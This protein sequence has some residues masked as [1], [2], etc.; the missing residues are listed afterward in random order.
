MRGKKAKEL[1]REMELK[2]A[3]KR[4]PAG[5]LEDFRKLLYV[6]WKHLRLPDPTP[7]QYDIAHF[8]QHG[9]KRKGIQGFRGV[10]K[11]WVTSA[12]VCWLLLRNPQE[13]ILV[14]SASKQRSDDFSTFTLR[15]I[16]EIPYLNHLIPNP[17]QRESKIAFD[18]APSMAAHA[19][20][21]KAA[22]IFG[23]ITGSRATHIIADDVEVA[24]NALTEDMRE[25]LL[26]AVS[27]FEAILVPEGETSITFLGTPQTHESIYNKMRE[28][29]YEF[30]VWPARYPDAVFL[31]D[32]SQDV[33]NGGLAPK[34]R[35]R[36]EANPK[37]SGEPTDPQRFDAQ[38]LM[39]RE[40]SYG[41]SGFGLQFMLDTTMSDLNRYPLKL[42][43][44]V[45]MDL[46][47]ERAPTGIQYGSGAEQHLK[48]IKGI[49]LAGDR[50]FGPMWYDK[51]TWT[52][53]EGMVMAIDPS[54]RGKDE[55]AY[56]I[57]A[58]LHGKLFLLDAG[59]L[60]GGYSDPVLKTLAIKAKKYKVKRILIEDNFG[61]GMFEALLKPH[62]RK[63]YPCT[64][65]GVRHNTMKEARIIDTLEPVL[66]QHRLVV[67][68]SL[69]KKDVAQATGS[70]YKDGDY[71]DVDTTPDGANA[72]AYSLFYQ[73]TRLTRERGSLKHDDR[74]DCVSIAVAY[75]L[76]SM[77]KDEQ[78]S[79]KDHHDNMLQKELDK[80]MDGVFGAQQ[81]SN[82]WISVYGH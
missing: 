78:V 18:V 77:S 15:L 51:D 65:E 81:R 21:V 29:R 75:W 61:D 53:Y 6:V 79:L 60:S 35:A 9:P 59:G 55:T 52:A 63:I 82:T 20:S 72:V 41:R 8:L 39:E 10:G 11:S 69:V 58:Q 5:V 36:L 50:W 2:K 19:P 13:K 48:D 34:L 1:R 68:T 49:G 17:D 66:N 23:Q 14:V 33:Y 40:I 56:C 54:G 32:S 73:L 67:N 44:L 80:F 43:D 24:Q 26:T 74:L 64:T 70:V 7:V 45:V 38:D 42:K 62:L 22:G 30:R 31:E 28:R 25:K 12:F 47:E 71:L 76:K 3:M 16:K 4:V 57:V 27:E 37:L 46:G